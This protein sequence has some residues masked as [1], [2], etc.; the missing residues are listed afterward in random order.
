MAIEEHGTKHTGAM[1]PL[2]N[3]DRLKAAF[4]RA[5]E[6]KWKEMQAMGIVF[7]LAECIIEGLSCEEACKSVV[8]ILIEESG[9]ENASILLYD[10]KDDIL[11]LVAAK[12]IEHILPGAPEQGYNRKLTF[13]RGH[14]IAWQ[15]Y[16]SQTPAFVEDSRKEGPLPELPGSRI[17]PPVSLAC[18]PLACQ[19]VI[20]L[21]ASWP[22]SMPLNRRR[23]LVIL[24]GVI[25]HL[26]QATE[27]HE[28]LAAS[29]NQLQYLV[30]SKTTELRHINEELRESLAYMQQVIESAPQ[31]ICLLERNGTVRH[32]NRA[33][34]RI[35]SSPEGYIVGNNLSKLFKDA[36]DYAELRKALRAGRLF[37]ITS[38]D[39]LRRNGSTFPADIFLHPLKGNAREELGYMLV[40]HDLSEQKQLTE[41]LL[42]AEKLKALGS[43]A[44]GV[45][46]DFNNLL[47]TVLGNVELLEMSINDTELL[48]RLKNI[49]MAV[50]DGAHSVRRL[51]AFT[52]F[53][54]GHKTDEKIQANL[55]AV[56]KDT[57]ELTRPK[58]KDDCEREGIK[59]DIKLDLN[60]NIWVAMH[61]S[62]LREVIT[63]I[64]FNATD[65]MP[66]GGTL[67]FR[68]HTRESYA[69]LEIQDTGTGMND[70]VKARIFDPYFTTKD[71]GNSGLG[72]S[73]SFGLVASAGGIITVE[74]KVGRG[75]KF[76][77]RLPLVKEISSSI[78]SKEEE[79][80]MTPLRILA[81]D[82]EEQIV[83]LLTI[84]LEGLG[85]KVEGF[86]DSRKAV[87]FLEKGDF[88]V[89][90]T[91][92][93]MPGINGWDVA[94]T[95]KGKQKP[96]RV[97]L[98]TGWGAQY[99]DQDL[100]AKGVD[101]VLC[102]PFRLK[103][104]TELM[105]KILSM[106]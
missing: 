67:S 17:N 8:D 47:A 68:A 36:A 96:P 85:H 2:C 38:V 97:I 75:S 106:T 104:L 92:L 13:K 25:G 83:D 43:M 90:L 14:G 84:M 30:D 99:E 34:S 60:K 37:K 81:V 102:K 48:K 80:C 50:T 31:G 23:D 59:I 51:Q 20:N 28:K 16:E 49:E 15:V 45:A 3:L 1:V 98:L 70:E 74:S 32:V 42:Q 33:L 22:V 41:K 58:W 57:L 39:L 66:A 65:A 72:L 6:E 19:G 63:N 64:V 87:N 76:K 10:S 35:F 54:Q 101:A 91:D 89:V 29:H 94:A 21:S 4:L 62:E 100:S 95:A 71:V 88:D 79:K 26:L 55:A 56:V 24:A 5:R 46:H 9:F 53:G 27:L 61:P 78:P 69:E 77:I 40:I 7:R 82:D 12:G 86:T 18:L 105:Q 103:D 73:V 11:K 44:G 52:G 93:G